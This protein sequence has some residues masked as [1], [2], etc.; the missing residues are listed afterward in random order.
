MKN[1]GRVFVRKKLRISEIVF[2]LG[3]RGRSETGPISAP[4]ISASSGHGRIT[5]LDRPFSGHVVSSERVAKAGSRAGWT[6]VRGEASGRTV[7]CR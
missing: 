7:E 1:I 4:L 5:A 2:N 3:V 6:S